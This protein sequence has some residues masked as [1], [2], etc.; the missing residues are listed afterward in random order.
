MNYARFKALLAEAEKTATITDDTEIQF[1]V[2][3]AQADNA[4][5][6]VRTAIS[7][8]VGQGVPKFRSEVPG[9]VAAP[10][11]PVPPDIP[12]YVQPVMLVIEG[13]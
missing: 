11:A 10:E 2:G 9:S 5:I 12:P 6:A 7:Y 4:V 13:S 8:T 3:A 1:R